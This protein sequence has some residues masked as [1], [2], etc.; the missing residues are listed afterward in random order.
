MNTEATACAENKGHSYLHRLPAAAYQGNA[1]VHWSMTLENRATGW[2]TP[3]LHSRFRE[4]LLHTVARY[5]LLCPAYCLMPDHL[6]ALLIGLRATSDQRVA[7]RFF[8]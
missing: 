4:L 3:L 6:H 7:V 1:Y 2:L 8:R 5:G